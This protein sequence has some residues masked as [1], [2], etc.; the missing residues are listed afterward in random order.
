MRY[1]D[2]FLNFTN[3]LIISRIARIIFN[4][5]FRKTN[6]RFLNTNPNAIGHLTIDIDCFL[7]ERE[8][9]NHQFNGIILCPKNKISNK[10]I[11]SCWEM[12]P[13]IKVIRNRLL[14]YVTDYLRIFDESSY[15]CSKY[16]ATNNK[17]FVKYKIYRNWKARNPIIELPEEIEKKGKEIFGKYLTGLN[18]NKIVLFH[19]RDSLF[20][21]S[22]GNHN[23]L[24][25]K[26]RNSSVLSYLEILKFL[27]KENYLV[28]RIGDY[29]KE[30]K[31]DEFYK[32]IDHLS[33]NDQ[34][35]LEC[36]L[37]KYQLFFLG[38]NSGPF[39]LAAIWNKPAFRLNILPYG[40]LRSMSENFVSIPKI[41]TK[42]NKKLSISE[43]FKKNIYLFN[44]DDY[45]N[46]HNIECQ[47][48]DGK[49]A[50]EDFKIFYE[51]F[52]LQKNQDKY[53][54]KYKNVINKFKKFTRNNAADY[55]ST[56][57]VGYKSLKKYKII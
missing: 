41:L 30:C 57:N 3:R 55:F 29:Y 2:R 45:Y 31:Y 39:G 48:I 7:K 12:S 15:D 33:Q 49:Y 34:R 25:Q 40:N 24:I 9:G 11:V 27:K 14:C 22:T 6:Y 16:Q 10:Y 5:F 42:N 17:P 21:K 38:S 1:Y 51:C 8:L 32:R 47:D 28:I 13:F 26:Y 35:L 18:T 36:Y 56:G 19:S 20:D 50:L 46:N 4:I 37:A 43:I 23:F 52:V 53:L 54:L 44:T